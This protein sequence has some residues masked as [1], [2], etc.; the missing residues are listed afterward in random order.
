MKI[1]SFAWT[2]AAFKAG[3]KSRTRRQW[4]EKHAKQFKVGDIIQAYDKN[5]LFK[6]KRIGFAR[7][8]GIKKESISKMPDKDFQKEGFAF[9]EE[10]GLKM[11]KEFGNQSPRKA[12][13]EWR[14]AGG[15]YY[16][17]DFQKVPGKKK[18]KN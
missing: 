16:V 14:K 7:I 10:K 11:P 18:G 9:M 4:G 5:P 17:I 3:R 6:G 8:T 12:F 1:I 13:N 2:S 15:T